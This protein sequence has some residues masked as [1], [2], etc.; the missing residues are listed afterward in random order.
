[1]S[2]RDAK[3]WACGLAAATLAADAD[4]G[5][6]DREGESEADQERKRKAWTELVEELRRRGDFQ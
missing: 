5:I 4:L 6:F 1:M 2:R 3:R